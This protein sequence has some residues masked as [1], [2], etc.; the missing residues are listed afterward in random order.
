[1]PALVVPGPIV[2]ERLDD[3]SGGDATF[4]TDSFA[5]RLES[6]RAAATN[7]IK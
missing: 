7:F 1:M 6:I 4:L 5:H 3:K 2:E